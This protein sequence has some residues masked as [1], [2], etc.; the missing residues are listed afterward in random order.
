M[1]RTCSWS[2]PAKGATPVASWNRIMPKAYTSDF[3]E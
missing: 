1:E 2:H 3:F